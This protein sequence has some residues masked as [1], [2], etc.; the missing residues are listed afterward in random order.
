MPKTF[1]NQYI[2]Q[3]SKSPNIIR[4]IQLVIFF[5]MKMRTIKQ[6][7]GPNVFPICSIRLLLF[8]NTFK[9]YWDLCTKF[10][11]LMGYGVIKAKNI[12]VQT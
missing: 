10:H 7:M 1:S 3:K 5:I 11:R 12:S 2:T 9:G 8:Q 6:R 4:N